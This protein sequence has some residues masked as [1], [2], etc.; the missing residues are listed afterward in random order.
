MRCGIVGALTSSAVDPILT[1]ESFDICCS[2]VGWCDPDD[3]LIPVLSCEVVV[4]IVVG[5]RASS[6]S[7]V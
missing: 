7:V 6:N 4:V 3:E 2:A 5:L 1:G